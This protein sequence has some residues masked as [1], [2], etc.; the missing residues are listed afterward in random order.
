[1]SFDVSDEQRQKCKILL[2]GSSFFIWSSE[3]ASNLRQHRIVG[4]LVGTMPKTP[5]QNNELTLPLKLMPEEVW[6]LKSRGL[7]EVVQYKSELIL[8]NSDERRKA[9]EQWVRL[10]IDKQSLE[11]H[12][13]N[14]ETSLAHAKDIALGRRKKQTLIS[15]DTVGEPISKRSKL[16]DGEDLSTTVTPDE[17]SSV[18]EELR[19][20]PVKR[21]KETELQKE[22]FTD[23][24]W[25][26]NS[27]QFEILSREF[28][29]QTAHE[30]L[31]YAAFVDLWEKGYFLTSGLKFGGDF[32]AYPGDPLIYH[33]SY[34]VVCVRDGDAASSTDITALCRLGSQVKKLV[35]L[36]S[37]NKSDNNKISYTSLQWKRFEER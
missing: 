13:R 7:A 1:M 29:P 6:F 10:E 19:E 35:L 24:P 12:Q 9:Y 30:K 16:D 5:T 20:T 32:L 31:R 36:C 2:V 28:G 23:P 17:V 34:V 8:S 26:H 11:Y 37:W 18:E 4:S 15:S 3:D 21:L 33:A 22:I 27:E 14:L 25:L